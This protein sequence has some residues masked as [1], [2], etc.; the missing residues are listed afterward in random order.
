[1][2]ELVTFTCKV[3]GISILIDEFSLYN[4]L[5]WNELP[6]GD[7]GYLYA[8]FTFFPPDLRL[9]VHMKQLH[10]GQWILNSIF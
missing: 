1:M 5:S 9:S 10:C 6:L 2:N 3:M 7:E 4:H 8:E